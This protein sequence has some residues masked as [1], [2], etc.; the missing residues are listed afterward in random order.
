[1]NQSQKLRFATLTHARNT[2]PRRAG[3]RFPVRRS[4]VDD[5]PVATPTF[6]TPSLR[7]LFY[8]APYLHDGS[9]ATLRDVLT[10]T[11]TT[12]GRT[13]HLSDEELDALVAY[14]LTL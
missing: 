11:A 13:D 4:T 12:M 9:A 2:R 10:Q 6:N 3:I 14:L 8:T 5:L 1:M 7:G